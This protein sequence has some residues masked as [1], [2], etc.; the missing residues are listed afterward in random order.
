RIRKRMM[1]EVEE[2]PAVRFG[3]PFAVFHGYIHAV[4][5]AVEISSAGWFGTRAVGKG[6]VKNA[7][8]FLD[9]DGPFREGAGLQIGIE[10]F[11][12]YKNW[13]VFGEARL[14]VVEAIGRQ[15]SANKAPM[16]ITLWPFQL[17]IRIKHR[18]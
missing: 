18:R 13:V 15:R 5:F 16:A 4:V 6:W 14:A 3:K 1:P 2:A 9:D 12:L 17:A 8:E 10:V 7:R 11:L